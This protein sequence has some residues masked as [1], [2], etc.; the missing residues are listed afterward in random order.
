MLRFGRI[1]SKTTTP[2]THREAAHAKVLV[3]TR[4]P[5]RLPSVS[6]RDARN[7]QVR[8][9]TSDHGGKPDVNEA[10]MPG[11]PQ[12]RCITPPAIQAKPASATTP[13]IEA[14]SKREPFGKATQA[15][16]R[17][18]YDKLPLNHENYTK[19]VE[20]PNECAVL[21][22]GGVHVLV[23]QCRMFD[24]HRLTF[25]LNPKDA[26]KIL[27]SRDDLQ[28]HVQDLRS[29][30]FKLPGLKPSASSVF[31]DICCLVASVPNRSKIAPTEQRKQL[32]Y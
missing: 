12:R 19:I 24:S 5:T 20:I 3:S 9:Y 27:A 7:T 16:F 26:A 28:S 32:G 30:V 1:V 22:K 8:H 4:H 2:H 6:T 18:V 15:L 25:P 14:R 31:C 29:V 10:Q 21:S 11:Q 17:N 23:I 13:Q